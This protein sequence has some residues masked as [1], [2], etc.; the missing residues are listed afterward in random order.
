MKQFR[1]ILLTAACLFVGMQLSAQGVKIVKKGGLA[2]DYNYSKIERIEVKYDEARADTAVDLGL[3]SGL[4]WAKFNIGANAP[5]EHGGYFAWGETT[6]KNVYSWGWYLC[7]QSECGTWADPFIK[8]YQSA[9]TYILGPAYDAAH[10]QWGGRWRMPT[11]EDFKELKE[12]C[13]CEKTTVNGVSGYRYTGWNGNSIFLPDGQ[14]KNGTN[15]TSD[16]FK[17]AY[18]TSFCMY[19]SIST[20]QQA[21]AFAPNGNLSKIDRAYGSAIRPVNDAST[22]SNIDGYI[23]HRTNGSEDYYTFQE[24][25]HIEAYLEKEYDPNAPSDGDYIDLG[26]PS[27][28]KWAS[29]NLGGVNPWDFGDYYAGYSAYMQ[30]VAVPEGYSIPGSANFEELIENCEVK[31]VTY[32]NVQGNMFTSK[33]NGNKIFLPFA[34]W[35]DDRGKYYSNGA[36]YW[37]F[38]RKAAAGYNNYFHYFL[39]LSNDYAYVD[40][41]IEYSGTSLDPMWYRYSIRLIHN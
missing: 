28:I 12:N 36:R 23:V 29:C 19:Y 37:S 21:S 30:E 5:E 38:S 8:N 6:E 14:I 39:H 22:G 31:T 34:G 24:V 16:L 13:S 11:D 41:E 17:C 27:G 25:D 32:N 33:I 9:G 10:I 40:Y 18:W 3:P 15:L 1:I 7:Q 20:A 2:V 26:L 35:Y 4:K